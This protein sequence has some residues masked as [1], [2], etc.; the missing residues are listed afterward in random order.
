MRF[1]SS[2]WLVPLIFF[3]CKQKESKTHLPEDISLGNSNESVPK[4]G[5]FSTFYYQ[6]ATDS[7]YQMEHIL[8]PLPGMPEMEDTVNYP[9]GF[10]WKRDNWVLHTSYNTGDTSFVRS[11]QIL[12]STLIIETIYHRISNLR[13]TRR[14]SKE[15]KGWQ[16]IYYSPLRKPV[17]IKIQ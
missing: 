4:E 1:N 7:E 12:D 17:E 16:L 2:I 8:F 3:A 9:G 14:F 13:L 10:S 5:G 15:K 6:F 11:F